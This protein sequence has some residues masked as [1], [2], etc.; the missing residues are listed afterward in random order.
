MRVG[1]SGLPAI[2]PITVQLLPLKSCWNCGAAASNAVHS[3]TLRFHRFY[4]PACAR[5]A[6]RSTS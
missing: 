5:A 4:C 6:H 3:L 2:P 1:P